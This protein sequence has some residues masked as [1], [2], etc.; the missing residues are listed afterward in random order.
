M[1]DPP[2]S[3]RELEELK[4]LRIGKPKSYA[5]PVNFYQ[6][7]ERFCKLTKDREEAERKKQLKK[8]KGES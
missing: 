8:L 5:Q 1:D 4:R 3:R 6:S 7:A 2:L